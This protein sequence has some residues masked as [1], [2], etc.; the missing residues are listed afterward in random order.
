MED[1]HII[2]YDQIKHKAFLPIMSQYM[3][4]IL[5][6]IF[7]PGF[8]WQV[9]LLDHTYHIINN[10]ILMT[11]YLTRLK[12]TKNTT[13]KVKQNIFDIMSSSS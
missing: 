9:K 11:E 10:Y 2:K 3:G 13:K 12:M 8:H 6:A 5:T 4:D 7:S 1:K